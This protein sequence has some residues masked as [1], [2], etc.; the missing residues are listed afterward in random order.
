MDIIELNQNEIAIVSG[1]MLDFLYL[2][3]TNVGGLIAGW[4]GA[5][6]M[7]VCLEYGRLDRQFI[8]VGSC[9][10]PPSV[11][12]AMRRA[13]DLLSMTA[14]VG[15]VSLGSMAYGLFAIGG[16]IGAFVGGC[17]AYPLAGLGLISID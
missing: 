3:G 8:R 11:G 4:G 14:F 7:R 6:A 17:I 13:S 1:G 5:A 9:G 16:N 10:E 15:L 12:L 2:A